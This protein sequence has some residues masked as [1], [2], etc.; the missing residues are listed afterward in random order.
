MT[1]PL[2]TTDA[3][4]WAKEF[5][6]TAARGVVIDEAHMIGWFANAIE[7]ARRD[8]YSDGYSAGCEEC[9]YGEDL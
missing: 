4:V 6:K 8:G 9:A 1:E 3:A 5:M 7:V 2:N